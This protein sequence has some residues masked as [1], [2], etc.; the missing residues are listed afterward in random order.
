MASARR[1]VIALVAVLAAGC[2]SSQCTLPPPTVLLQGSHGSAVLRVEVA[3]TAAERARG[4]MGRR[5]LAENAGMLFEFPQPSTAA[6]WM[7]DTLIPLSIAFYVDKGRIVTIRDM[8]PCTH[9]P[10]RLYRSSRPY[11]G[12][13]E[14]NRGY[15][16]RH[17]IG[18]GDRVRVRIAGCA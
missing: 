15:F 14:A 7:K 17:G 9:A 1:S 18:I 4:L 8:R 10:C 2:H 5:S 11:V 16:H 3:D 12:A 6:F 13:I